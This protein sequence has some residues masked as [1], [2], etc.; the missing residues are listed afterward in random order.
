MKYDTVETINQNNI[1]DTYLKS[2]EHDVGLTIF[3]ITFKTILGKKFVNNLNIR[4]K[5]AYHRRKHESRIRTSQG[6]QNI[7]F[8]LAVTFCYM[9]ELK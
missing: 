1:N 2:S 6:V 4:K 9:R 7:K 8:N 5:D 3:I